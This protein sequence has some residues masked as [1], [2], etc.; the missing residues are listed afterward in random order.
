MYENMVYHSPDQTLRGPFGA[1]V[2]KVTG[3]FETGAVR[4]GKKPS[5]T[6]KPP[7]FDAGELLQGHEALAQMV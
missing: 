6:P 1:T 7:L 3:S 4:G 2:D 5:D